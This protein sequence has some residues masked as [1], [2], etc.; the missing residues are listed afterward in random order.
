MKNEDIAKVCHEANRAYC[1]TLGEAQPSWEEAPKWQRDSALKGVQ[2][3]LENPNASAAASH[4]SWLAEKR[5]QGWTYGPIKNAEKKEHP[6]F[7]PFEALPIAQQLKDYLFR[8][9]VHACAT[10]H[11]A[12]SRGE[13]QS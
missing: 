2:F 8:S 12:P 7:V 4:E 13:Q 9:T 5:G 1:A 11:G 6:C 10:F 3:H